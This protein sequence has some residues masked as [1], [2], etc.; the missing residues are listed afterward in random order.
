M[1]RKRALI[2]FNLLTLLLMMSVAPVVQPFQDETFGSEVSARATTTWSGTVQLT[3]DYFVNVQNELLIT[4][5]TSIVM[6]PG[7]RI[8]VDG[9]L[10]VQGTPTCPIVLSSS[11]TTS[12]HEG[13]Q[14]NSSSNGRGSTINHMH[15]EDA[16]FGMTLYGSDPILNNVTIFNPDRV[17]IDMFGSS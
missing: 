7:I 8:Y 1:E 5:C 14:F 2:A 4:S 17:G 11:S 6:S 12:D 9:R 16:V 10:T 3:S 13:I 15:I